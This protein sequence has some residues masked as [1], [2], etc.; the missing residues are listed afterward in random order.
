MYERINMLDNLIFSLNST[1]PLFLIMLLGY[2][3]KRKIS[4]LKDS[5]LMQINL[6][7]T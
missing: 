1:I 6:C 4:F 3:L 5:S 7:F 2:F